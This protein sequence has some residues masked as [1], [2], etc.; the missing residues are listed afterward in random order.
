MKKKQ[1]PTKEE[2][3]RGLRYA[4]LRKKFRKLVKIKKVKY[5][6]INTYPSK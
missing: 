2:F 3:I 6:N 5:G 1:F 4:S